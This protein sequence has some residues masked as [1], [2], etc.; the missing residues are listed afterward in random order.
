V[1]HADEACKVA[2]LVRFKSST[3][4]FPRACKRCTS[5]QCSALRLTCLTAVGWT[6]PRTIDITLGWWAGWQTVNWL[7]VTRGAGQ[8]PVAAGLGGLEAA[9]DGARVCRGARGAVVGARCAVPGVVFVPCRSGLRLALLFRLAAI[10]LGLCCRCFLCFSMLLPCAVALVCSPIFGVTHVCMVSAELQFVVIVTGQEWQRPK[11]AAMH[12]P[13]CHVCAGSCF[14]TSWTHCRCGTCCSLVQAVAPFQEGDLMRKVG[15]AA[16]P[17]VRPQRPASDHF[18]SLYIS[19]AVGVVYL[20]S[21][22]GAADLAAADRV[23]QALL[24]AAQQRHKQGPLSSMQVHEWTLVRSMYPSSPPRLWDWGNS[25]R[26]PSAEAPGILLLLRT[27]ATLLQYVSTGSCL[28]LRCT[29]C[30][31]S[32]RR[33]AHGRQHTSTTS[34]C[35]PVR[36]CATLR[37]KRT[38]IRRRCYRALMRFMTKHMRLQKPRHRALH[39]LSVAMPRRKHWSMFRMQRRRRTSRGVLRCSSC[40]LTGRLRSRHPVR[41]RDRPR[42]TLVPGYVSAGYQERSSMRPVRSQGVHS[43]EPGAAGHRHEH[44]ACGGRGAQCSR[45]ARGSRGARLASAP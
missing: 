17:L 10:V 39:R 26:P 2:R 29:T 6:P 44:R 4:L 23:C 11:G 3:R 36:T 27:N 40:A 35:A 41:Q 32:S 14:A 21:A 12:D 20:R 24:H 18:R 34:W 37:S 45:L 38:A 19:A 30:A 43:R 25:T 33:C 1:E 42:G 22:Q 13:N 16:V 8:P 15:A 28:Q 7:A 9:R 5:L 31:A